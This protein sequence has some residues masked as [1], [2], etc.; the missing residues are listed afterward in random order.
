MSIVQA[1]YFDDDR[2]LDMLNA[3]FPIDPT[4]IQGT[5]DFSYF[6]H[7]KI[8]KLMLVLEE[9]LR[10]EK[11]HNVNLETRERE[12]LTVL[13]VFVRRQ[14]E[15]LFDNEDIMV[16]GHG[17]AALDILKSGKMQCKYS[18]LESYFIPLERI[19]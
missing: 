9:I 15:K 18:D 3:Y 12:K 1:Y 6:D 19:G 10:S 2:F 16:Y 8:D 17:G 11:I 4:N 14:I 7:T 13:P 5:V